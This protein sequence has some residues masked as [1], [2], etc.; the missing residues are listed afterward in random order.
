MHGAYSTVV[1]DCRFEIALGT[2]DREQFL[3]DVDKDT[4]GSIN[5]RKQK[6]M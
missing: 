1:T 6:L 4:E 2:R 5:H 3:Q